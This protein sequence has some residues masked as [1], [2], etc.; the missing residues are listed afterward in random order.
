MRFIIHEQPYEQPLRAGAYRFEHNGRATGAVERWR[1]SAAVDGYQFLRV[2]LD[3]RPS[4]GHTYLYHALL[5]PQGQVERLKYRFWN[6]APAGKGRVQLTGDV[7]LAPPNAAPP[8]SAPTA[9][10]AT[11]TLNGERFEQAFELPPGFRFW[12]PSVSGLHFASQTHSSASTAVMLNGQIGGAET[13]A[14]QVVE[15]TYEPLDEPPVTITLGAEERRYRRWRLTWGAGHWRII[16]RDASSANG[17]AA[18][19]PL[20]MERPA[21]DGSRKLTAVATRC[22]HYRL[23]A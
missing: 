19:W 15:S 5:N 11:R 2:D 14:A 12:F 10:I 16:W 22:M 13:L 23:P 9:V 17:D 6:Q 8:A 21:A 4:S 20:G 18:G 1:L 7:L 3:G